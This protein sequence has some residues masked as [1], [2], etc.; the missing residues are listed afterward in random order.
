LRF[1]FRECAASGLVALCL[2]MGLA[3]QPASGRGSIAE[4]QSL[5]RSK[6]YD[7]ALAL[8]T[9]SL[10][11]APDDYRLWTIQ[12]IALSLQGQKEPAVQSFEHA[13]QLAPSYTPALKGEVQILFQNGD[14]RAIPVLEKIVKADPIDATAHEMLANLERKEEH[15]AAANQHFALAEQAISTHPESLEA[16][17]YCLFTMQQPEK[18]APVFERLVALL[19][20]RGYARYDLAVVQVAAQQYESA[21]ATLGPLLTAEQK[22]A[23]VFSLAS[24]AYEKLKKTPK[25]VELLRQAI[26]LSPTTPGYYASF[27]A[28]CLE[29]D[30][31]QT[32]VDMMNVGLKNIP[33]DASLYLSR[34]L[35]YV[36]LA[37]FEKA[38]ADFARVE[39][40]S[41]F[42][43]L[44]S[45]ALDL[46]E[47]QRN[48]PEQALSRVRSQLR[49]HPDD[50]LLNYFLAQS[51][52]NQSPDVQSDA[53]REALSAAHRVVKARPD[54]VAAHDLLASMYMHANQYAQAIEECRTA[55]GYDPADEGATYHLLIALKHTGHTEEL[56]GLSKRLAQLHRESLQHENE[57]KS[58]RLIEAGGPADASH[59]AANASTP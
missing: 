45:Y 56:A 5:I 50:P 19:P 9:T 21:I 35:L 7:N 40:L 3:E 38:E 27:A 52:M 8:I 15:C 17:G 33:G 47:V 10:Q 58:F 51:L 24:Q 25:A 22:D 14:R 13:I 32:G 46:T 37:D 43:A 28:L 31:F 53:Y 44:G 48:N 6:Q 39:K 11:T 42:Q 55:L 26:V 2:G 49:D 20:D 1:R 12:G 30:S 4:I 57:R 23:D 18:A 16:Y 34:G 29:H 36:E 59:P 54:Y 41:S